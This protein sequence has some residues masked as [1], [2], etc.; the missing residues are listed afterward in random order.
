METEQEAIFNKLQREINFL[1][2]RRG[3]A[4][5]AQQVSHFRKTSLAGTEEYGISPTSTAS[6][7]S[8]YMP[9]SVSS[10]SLSSVSSAVSHQDNTGRERRGSIRR[11]SVCAEDYEK[12]KQEN[13]ML[14][15]KLRD[16]TLRLAD[17]EHE[18]DMLRH[19]HTAPMAVKMV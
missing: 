6:V 8:V 16:L 9:N 13:E 4:S 3:S 19:K 17:K 11:G 14:K 18:V 10:S 1:K 15:N 12:L 5:D 2:D 7:F